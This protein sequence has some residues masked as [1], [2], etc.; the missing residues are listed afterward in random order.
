MLSSHLFQRRVV[1]IL[2]QGGRRREGKVAERQKRG[3][4]AEETGAVSVYPPPSLT[5]QRSSSVPRK[6]KS[7]PGPSRNGRLLIKT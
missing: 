6:R 1:L 7:A 2:S 3:K 5:E 4:G